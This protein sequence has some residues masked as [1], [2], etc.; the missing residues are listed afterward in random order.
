M[1]EGAGFGSARIT[2]AGDV[3]DPAAVPAQRQGPGGGTGFPLA[4][5][6]DGMKADGS[7]LINRPGLDQ[8]EIPALVAYLTRAPVVLSAPGTAR[9]EVLPSAPASVPRAFHTDGT[10]VW[11]AAVG[12]YLSL[13]RLPPQGELL[14][15]IRTRG[16][17]LSPVQPQVV[18]AAAAQVMA[19][20]KAR[21]QQPQQ[22]Q[23]QPQ[24]AQLPPPRMPTV[25]SLA[26]FSAAFNAAGNRHAAWVTEQLETFLDFMPLGGWSVD[27]TTRR[28]RQSGRE[29]AVDALGTLSADGVWTWAWS[30][31]ATWG[32][33]PAIVEQSRGLRSLGEQE[34]IAEL[35]TPAFGL[36]GIEDAPEGPQDAAEMIAWTAMGLLGAR[37]Y[38][39]HS[40]RDDGSGGRV[41]YVVCD[42]A[43]PA[44][45]P[46]LDTMPRFMMEGAATFGEDAAGCVLGYVE[47]HGWDWSRVP[48]GIAV[49]AEGIG[50]FTAE[51]S[52]DGE[53]AGVSVRA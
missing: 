40:A 48:E 35:V 7:P 3:T 12:Y 10:W 52:V 18:K 33:N 30:D 15:H 5:V 32:Q 9:D 50:A 21:S 29:F 16:Y 46:R 24:R 25:A 47:H 1:S 20:L 39:G 2:A 14:E 37:G 43:V 53:L 6:F 8:Q 41:Y 34:G 51:L 31:A 27:H 22:S 13:Y 49:V 28:Y 23:Q 4:R 26:A 42:V 19:V 45:S 11:P 44:A 38:I 17:A 36:A